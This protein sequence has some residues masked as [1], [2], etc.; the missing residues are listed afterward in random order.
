MRLLRL[1]SS[2]REHSGDSSDPFGSTLFGECWVL[3]LS[4]L[5]GAARRECSSDGVV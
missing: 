3:R 1:R 4:A 5:L 2:Q